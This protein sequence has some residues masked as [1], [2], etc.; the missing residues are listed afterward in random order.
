MLVHTTKTG[1]IA[2][3]N[4]LKQ[5]GFSRGFVPTMGA[6]HQGHLSLVKAALA[7]NKLVVVSIFVNPIQFG[8]KEDFKGYPRTLNKD[9]KM[10]HLKC[11]PMHS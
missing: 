1:L 8:P 10:L 9:K 7:M 6:L 11:H 2:H 4:N 3:I 5:P